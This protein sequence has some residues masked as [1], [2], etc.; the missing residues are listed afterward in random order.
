MTE[1][2]ALPIADMHTGHVTGLIPPEYDP[3]P[4][5]SRTHEYE[6]WRFRRGSWQFFTVAVAKLRPINIAML[7]GDIVDGP[8]RSARDYPGQTLIHDRGVQAEAAAAIINWV[9]AEKVVAVHGTP[10]HTG[11]EESWEEQAFRQI[12]N[13]VHVGTRE[14]WDV[15]GLRVQAKHNL[16]RSNTPYGQSGM[17]SKSAVMQELAAL[18][19]REV[20]APLMLRAHVHLFVGVTTAYWQ[21]YALPALQGATRYADGNGDG[22]MADMGLV[23]IKVRNAQ[24]WRVGWELY[25]P[26]DPE[27]AVIVL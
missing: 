1:V 21:I 8:D 4:D 22:P 5:E 16:S 11:T 14:V 10:R 15:A 7:M 23:W 3:E 25:Q 6:L 18:H 12:H 27:S 2:T 19:E 26:Y 20:K 13:I 17:L 24:S 9:G